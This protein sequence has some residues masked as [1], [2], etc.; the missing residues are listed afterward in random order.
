MTGFLF[1]DLD[2]DAKIFRSLDKNKNGKGKNRQSNQNNMDPGENLMQQFGLG[3]DRGI[4]MKM[5]EKNYETLDSKSGTEFIERIYSFDHLNNIRIGF[6]NSIER[7]KY[8]NLMDQ[9]SSS[10]QL[11]KH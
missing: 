5:F 10:R 11:T 3:G 8:K 6:K 1:R 9:F 7:Y 4:G 2:E